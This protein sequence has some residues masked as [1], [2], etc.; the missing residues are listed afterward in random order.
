MR[1]SLSGWPSSIGEAGFPRLLVTHADITVNFFKVSFLSAFFA[2]PV[3]VFVCFIIR[4]WRYLIPY[5]ALY[6]MLF[7]VCWGMMQLAPEPF[8]NWWRD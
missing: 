2:V 7:F 3:A 6:G 4:R 8:L 1:Q 5:L